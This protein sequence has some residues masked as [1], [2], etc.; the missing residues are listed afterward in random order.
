MARPISSWK[1]NTRDLLGGVHKS[2]SAV[3]PSHAVK[4]GKNLLLSPLSSL[5]EISLLIPN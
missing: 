1:Q 5:R 4:E 3:D 2:F